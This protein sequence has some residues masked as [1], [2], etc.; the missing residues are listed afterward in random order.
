MFYIF[1]NKQPQ[2][3]LSF[4]LSRRPTSTLYTPGTSGYSPSPGYEVVYFLEKAGLL[5]LL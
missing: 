5:S 2:L 3:D 1:D 4:P